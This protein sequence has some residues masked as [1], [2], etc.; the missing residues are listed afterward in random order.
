MLCLWFLLF[1]A[2]YFASAIY[3]QTYIGGTAGAPYA[4][5]KHFF[6]NAWDSALLPFKD[7]PTFF[8]TDQHPSHTKTLCDKSIQLDN[9][10][11]TV[12]AIE[13]KEHPQPTRNQ[14]YFQILNVI[15]TSLLWFQCFITIGYY[16]LWRKGSVKKERSGE[17]FKRYVASTFTHAIL[18]G[19]SLLPPIIFMLS[20]TEAYQP[21]VFVMAM[22]AIFV[23]AE[24]YGGLRE[25][26]KKLDENVDKLSEK[27]ETIL[28]ADGLDTWKKT[29]YEDYRAAKNR[30]DAIIRHFDIDEDWWKLNS[31]PWSA[32]IKASRKNSD[33]LLYALGSKE[34]E[35]SVQFVSG[36]SIPTFYRDPNEQAHYFRE[37]LG[38]TWQLVVLSEARHMRDDRRPSYDPK[39][40]EKYLRIKI[41]PAP[42]WMHVVDDEVNQIIE[43]VPIN[44]STVRKLSC[45]PGTIDEKQP[46]RDWARRNIRRT[47]HR[48]GLGEEYVCSTLSL[49]AMHNKIP[50]SCE[51]SGETLTTLL[52][53]L[54]M[55]EYLK[56]GLD[57]RIENNDKQTPSIRCQEQHLCE[58]IFSRFLENY[59]TTCITLDARRSTA[60]PRVCDLVMEIL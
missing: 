2:A 56:S 27:L 51:L 5:I 19:L 54:G 6:D 53:S 16:K 22:V 1:L 40:K 28:N 29:L 10:Q 14:T 18:K 32:Y 52:K 60:H 39:A 58:A 12:L 4:Q 46:L 25:T 33:T 26:E 20:M 36:I 34:S 45:A 8:T 55:N 7:L 23:A 37:L 48:G 44:Q 13:S 43:R 59:C 9:I 47:A 30:I 42:F 3:Y 21:A 50:Y 15:L 11:C 24:H 35:A 17:K 31:D 49:A 41:A 57:F 38:L